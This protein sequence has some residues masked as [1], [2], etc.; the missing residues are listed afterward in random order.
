MQIESFLDSA[1]FREYTLTTD[2]VQQAWLGFF[3]V[4]VAV[5]IF[6]VIACGKN[7]RKLA[8]VIS[9]VNSSTMMT[10]GIVYCLA[11][12]RQ[13]PDF[14]TLDSSYRYALHSVDNFS[15]LVCIWFALANIFDIIVGS[16]FYPKHL[17]PLTAYVHHTVA[18]WMTYAGTTGNGI[19][20]QVEVF[21][22]YFM[23]MTLVEV[24]TFLLALGAVF[25]SL[26]TD[27]GFGVTFF[28][29]RLVYL[30]WM[31][32]CTYILQGSMT[33]MVLAFGFFI[34]HIFWFSNWISKYGSKLF[35]GGKKTGKKIV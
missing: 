5:S 8:W 11:K 23:V 28:I 4:W 6:G 20:V 33:I 3:G 9:L 25:P 15:A 30:V 22:S 7:D 21:A 18:I 32:Y 13:Y 27:I 35:G 1:H 12:Y 31:F 14:F 2:Q 29:F 10:A 34:L 24:P 16:L 26:R 17:D 19:F